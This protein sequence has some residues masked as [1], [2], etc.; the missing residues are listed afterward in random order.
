MAAGPGGPEAEIRAAGR[1]LLDTVGTVPADG[2]EQ[3]VL[4]RYQQLPALNAAAGQIDALQLPEWA[5][6]RPYV[7]DFLSRA[8]DR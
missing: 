7:G 2:L 5:A 6:E 3:W 8:G 4:L 1:T